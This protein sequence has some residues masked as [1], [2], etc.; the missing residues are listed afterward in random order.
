[1]GEQAAAPVSYQANMLEV[2]NRKAG[3]VILGRI[4]GD[5]VPPA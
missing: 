4:F 1:M 5:L 2:T 3:A